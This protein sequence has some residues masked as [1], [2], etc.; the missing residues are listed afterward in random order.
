V[1]DDAL[2][3]LPQLLVNGLV[4]RPEGLVG[5]RPID[6]FRGCPV[7]E[8]ADPVIRQKNPV[9]ALQ[10]VSGELLGVLDA[11]GRDPVKRRQNARYN[12]IPS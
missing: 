7:N 5:P 11:P 4:S 3:L 8:V 1:F 6:L 9:E 2:S 10:V 12:Q